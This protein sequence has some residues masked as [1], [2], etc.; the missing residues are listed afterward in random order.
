[1]AGAPQYCNGDGVTFVL[2]AGEYVGMLF[3]S[4]TPYT[5][6]SSG[7][8]YITVKQRYYPTMIAAGIPP[9]TFSISES[10]NTGIY[11]QQEMIVYF[12]RSAACDEDSTMV[13]TITMTKCCADGVVRLPSTCPVTYYSGTE[14]ACHNDEYF[15]ALSSAQAPILC[16]LPDTISQDYNAGYYGEIYQVVP[17]MSYTVTSE[18]DPEEIARGYPV[19]QI[20]YI[21]VTQGDPSGVVLAAGYSPLTFTAKTAENVYLHWSLNSD[22][23]VE[24][25]V[26]RVATITR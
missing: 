8:G 10:Q 16:N 20:D 13:T 15:G 17:G 6:T 1:M 3:D 21:T 22:C 5:I 23:E 2:K 11:N 18:A 4:D 14:P 9:L 7:G 19:E 12:T 25:F 24:E 26:Y